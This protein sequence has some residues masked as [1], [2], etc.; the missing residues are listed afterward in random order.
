MLGLYLDKVFVDP[1][2]EG[3]LLHSVSLICKG[4]QIKRGLWRENKR[5]QR[6]RDLMLEHCNV[7]QENCSVIIVACII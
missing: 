3:L 2:G 1:F 7:M 5:K 4:G 6:K